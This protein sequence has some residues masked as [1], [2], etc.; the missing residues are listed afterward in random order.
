MKPWIWLRA[1]TALQA[2]GTFGHTMAGT[3][4]KATRGPQEEALF[5]AMRAF[6]LTIMGSN[7]SHW[8]FYQ[9][10]GVTITVNFLVLT[11]LLWQLSSLSRTDSK[12]VRPMV[13]TIL[14]GHLLLLVVGSI[15]FFLAPV[16][17]STLTVL[18]LAMALVEINRGAQADIATPIQLRAS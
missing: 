9:G 5:S 15:Y 11:I 12:V 7:R 2:F 4:V 16:L 8:D 17:V 10:F 3:P 18:C 6:R 14:F 1:A 13:I